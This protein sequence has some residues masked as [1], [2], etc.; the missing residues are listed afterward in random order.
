MSFYRNRYEIY[1][2]L[3]VNWYGNDYSNTKFPNEILITY[4]DIFD[5]HRYLNYSIEGKSLIENVKNDKVK[6]VIIPFDFNPVL[7]DS[8]YFYLKDKEFLNHK[9][10]SFWSTDKIDDDFEN[11]TW[12]ISVLELFQD[13]IDND[14]SYL[15]KDVHFLCLNGSKKPH[16]VFL[17]N[18]LVKNDILKKCVYS[19]LWEGIT[20]DLQLEDGE[21][22]G[23]ENLEVKRKIE[24]KLYR[25]DN[26]KNLYEKCLIEIVTPTGSNLVTEKSLK[27]LING[28]PFLIFTKDDVH[29]RLCLTNLVFIDTWYKNIGVDINYFKLD[30]SDLNSV[31]NK[32]IELSNMSIDEIKN[33]YSDVFELAEKNKKII[34]NRLIT[35]L[36]TIKHKKR[37]I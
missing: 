13:F 26:I 4:H 23:H 35:Y 11:I 3:C 1:R 7:A 19:F 18:F 12:G 29:G 22:Y 17:K 20:P 14:T 9:N 28:V 8:K 15:K 24:N 25:K 37:F 36:K 31:E 21:F 10:I 5:L 2:D 27:P 30:Y 6:C 34:N 32:I 33:K 16:R